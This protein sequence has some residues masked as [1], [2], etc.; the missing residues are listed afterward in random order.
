MREILRG[1]DAVTFIDEC[2]GTS[3]AAAREQYRALELDDRA[4]AAR[5]ASTIVFLWAGDS[6]NDTVAAWLTKRGLQAQNEGL[7]VQ[8]RSGDL[9][10]IHDALLDL[11]ES[12]YVDV[13][14]LLPDHDIPFEEKWE[15]LLP[16]PLLRKQYA[17]RIF[18]VRAATMAVQRA[19]GV[20]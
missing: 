7:C 20:S 5:G 15:W 11:A 18:D 12:P 8:V 6:A 1:T 3:L 17:S 2:A 14:E 4:L 9:T 19:L 10:A 13:D 16:E